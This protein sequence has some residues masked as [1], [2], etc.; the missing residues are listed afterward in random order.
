M[1]LSAI[2]KRGHV[3]VRAKQAFYRLA[4]NSPGQLGAVEGKFSAR[5]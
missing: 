4:G 2:S 5:A 3:R 1:I